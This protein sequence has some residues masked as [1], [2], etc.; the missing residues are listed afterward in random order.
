[1]TSSAA[2]RLPPLP[3]T[4]DL[5]RLYGIRSKRS[6]SQNFILDPRTLDKIARTAGPLAGQ[7]VV[8]IG[9]GPGGITRALIGNGARQVVVIEKDARFLSPL[10][11]LQEAAQ[12]RIIINMGDVLKVNLSKFLDAELRQPWDSPQVPDIRL[13]SNLPFNITMPF[14]VRTIRDMAA[15]DNLFSYGRVPAVL[16][17]QKEVAERIIAQPGDRNRSRLSVLCQNFAQAR[18]KYTLKGGSFVPAASVDVGVMTLLPLRQP[19][20]DLPF[21]FLEKVFTSLFHGK[22][23]TVRK[24]IGHLF[25]NQNRL[26]RADI[27]LSTCRIHP[28]RTAVSLDMNDFE[29]IAFTYKDMCDKEPRLKKY[30]LPELR[31]LL[32]DYQIEHGLFEDQD[33]LDSGSGF[34]LTQKEHDEDENRPSL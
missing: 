4:R 3:S 32:L 15:H 9:P 33:V 29:K 13:V 8:E 19:Y 28:N 5:L 10:R 25:P 6:L 31:E 20:I 1:M 24:T 17:F 27:L 30:V 22:Q 21:N 23:K 16:T 7:T 18:L 11:L 26:E 2:R 34:S 14:L 12:G